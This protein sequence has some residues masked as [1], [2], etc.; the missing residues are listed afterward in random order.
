MADCRHAEDTLFFVAEEDWRLY[1]SDCKGAYGLTEDDVPEERVDELTAP[2]S[3]EDVIAMRA[4][5]VPTDSPFQ[6]PQRQDAQ[7]SQPVHSSN[8]EAGC[9]FFSKTEKAKAPSFEKAATELGD[10]VRIF[11]SAA[12]HG[13]GDLV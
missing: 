8:A 6:H 3:I 9:G 12:R 1:R 2:Q 4:A 10:L 11:N 13:R 7:S 5:I